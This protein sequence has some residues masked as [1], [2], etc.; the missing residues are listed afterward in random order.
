M[1]ANNI[2]G[3]PK[4]MQSLLRRFANNETVEEVEGDLMEF[5]KQWLTSKGKRRA[6]LKY[7]LTAITLLRPL[8]RS[9]QSDTMINDMIKSYFVMSWRTILRNK[10]SSLI[11]LMG[12]A[13]GLATSLL[14]LLVVVKEFKYDEH[15]LKKDSIFLI[16]KN[17]KTNDGVSTGRST[18]GPLAETLKSDYAPVVHAGR[19]A[20]FHDVAISVDQS[21]FKESGIYADPDIFRMMTFQSIKGDAASA[22]DRNSI[23]I[24]KSMAVKLFN[25]IDP[26]GREIIFDRYK[27]LSIGAVIEDIPETSTVKFQIAVPFNVFER[28][29][30]WLTKWDDNRIQT[31][32]ELNSPQEISSFNKEIYSLI[33]QK[34]KDPNE[35]LFA[36]PM[37][38]LHL[39]GGFSNGQPS[40]G[41][42]T[43]IW[44]LLGFGMFMLLIACVNFMNVATA[45]SAHRAR[46][47]G[48][49]KVLGSTRRWIVFQFLNEA[50]VITSVAMILAIVLTILVIP[51]FNVL[52]HA[53]ISFDYSD[54]VVWISVVTVTL[55]TALIAGSYPAFVLSRFAPAKVL[56]GIVD[57]PRGI[58]LRRSLVTFQFTIST[59]VLVGTIILY[60]QFEHVRNRPMGYDQQNLVNVVLDSLASARF[61]V[62]RNEVSKIPGVTSVTG[63]GGNILYSGG[64]ITGLDWPGRRPGEELSIVIVDTDYDWSRTMGIEIEK[65]RDFSRDHTSD[66]NSC[67]LNQAAVEKMGLLNPIGS[68]VGGKTVIGVFKDY[69]Y[70]NPSGVIAPMIVFL[71][72]SNVHHLYARIDN[73][74]TWMETLSSIESAVRKASPD[75]AFDFKFTLD[76]YNTRFSE[77]SDIGLMIS[78]FSG[79]TIFISCLGLFGLSG[80][81]AERRAKEMSIRK[82]LGADMIRVLLALS[83]DVLAPVCLALLITIPFAVWMAN[84]LLAEFVYHVSLNAWMFVRAVA[85]VLTIS[86]LIVSY[87][88]WRTAAES[89]MKRLKVE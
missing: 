25:D 43:I 77:L 64:S 28:V 54:S 21:S 62:I 74:N 79:M 29:N 6:D 33:Q 16:M 18:P 66:K 37:E 68:Q 46:E 63:T 47:V 89:P 82:V 23:V 57:H 1:S 45:Q 19:V 81:V 35:T 38:R 8:A 4:W 58:S 67:L 85:L 52:M 49:R 30:A 20:W 26:V 70:N 31:W 13:L 76:E 83:R 71:S 9:K 12:L 60:A 75:I 39:Y 15:I 3:P 11:N 24:T 87:H 78:V 53:S 56:K 27:S 10:V 5:Y 41:L 86:S 88:G 2:P 69:V 48:M 55:V 80:F 32:V 44:V 7:L 42:I 59:I 65:G 34:T 50:V 36:Y 84:I 72:P 22:M 17:Q 51:S 14:I 61:D 40:G 73:N